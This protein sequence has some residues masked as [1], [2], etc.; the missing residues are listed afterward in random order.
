MQILSDKHID[1]IYHLAD[2]HIRPLDRHDEYRHV[3]D[4]LY[5]FLKSKE[6]IKDSLI[7]ICGDIIHEKDK[8]TPELILLLRE[9]LKNLSEITDVV[10]FSGNHDLIEN[11]LER[12]P[13]LEALTQ[14]ISDNIHY[15]RYTGSYKY[16]SIVFSLISL[17]DCGTAVENAVVEND[18]VENKEDEIIKIGLYHGMLKEIAHS[19]GLLSVT[20][21]E[22]YDYVLLGD[23]HERQFLKDNIAYSGSL[24]QQNFGETLD[25]HGL[26]RWDLYNN[27]NECIDIPNDY[28]YVTIT[29]ENY[30]M[31]RLPKNS[32]IRLKLTDDMD[33][34]KVKSMINENTN[35]ISEKII[36]FKTVDDKIKYEEQFIKNIN[37][38]DIIREQVLKIDKSKLD[39][40][41]ELHKQIKEECDFDS[42]NISEYKWSIL[43]LEFKNLF[44]YGDNILNKVDFTDKN[45]VIGILGN[46]A[47]G[48]SSIINIIIFALF[49]KIS[50]EYKNSANVINKNSKKMYVKIEFIVG[51][52][53][54]IIEKQGALQ[55]MKGVFRSKFE[56]NFKKIENE[57]EINLNGKDQIR[58][59]QLIVK[60][61][62]IQDIFTL[63]NI[64]S[65]TIVVSLLNMSDTE[66]INTFSKLFYLNIYE[67]FEKNITIK[68]KKINEEYNQ[69]KGRYSVLCDISDD[70]IIMKK[71][72]FNEKRKV[73]TKHSNELNKL[74]KLFNTLKVRVKE[75][76][77]AIKFIEKPIKS[78]NDLIIRQEYLSKIKDVNYTIKYSLEELYKNYHNE[79]KNTSDIELDDLKEIFKNLNTPL[80]HLDI[81]K[82][83]EFEHKLIK[84]NYN[85]N[86][87]CNE[88]QNYSNHDISNN[89]KTET[90]E[91]LELLKDKFKLIS[92]SDKQDIIECDVKQIPILKK[93]I[94]E[95]QVIIFSDSNKMALEASTL[96]N[97]L[98]DRC[99]YSDKLEVFK[100]EETN[101]FL[102]KIEIFL[103]RLKTDTELNN[104]LSELK[105]DIKNYDTLI[106]HDK[107]N[108]KIIELNKEI[109]KN[110]QLN[111][112]AKLELDKI[113]KAISF[114]K[115]N[116]LNTKIDIGNKAKQVLTDDIQEINDYSY[117][118]EI[119][120]KI[121]KIEENKQ[122]DK[123]ITYLKQCSELKAINVDLTC[124]EKYENT[125]EDNL[126]YQAEKDDCEFEM[127]NLNN[128]IKQ[129]SFEITRINTEITYDNDIIKK[130]KK[131]LKEKIKSENIQA[132]MENKIDLY[133]LYKKL[134]DKKCIRALLLKEKLR[135]IENDINLHLDGLVNFEIE[136][137]M[138]DNSKFELNIIK[139]DIVLQP[140]MCS[141]YERFILNIMIKNSLNRYSYNN[142]S[143][144]FCIDEGLDCIDDNNLKKFKVV[145]D[146]LQQTYN[147]IILISQIDRIDKYI[148]YQIL[149]EHK[150]NS[151][152]IKAE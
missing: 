107:H 118:Y 44:I 76:T 77:D 123:D 90:V 24:I 49:G 38:E 122:T 112:K 116:E 119:E 113:N 50:G 7:V 82:L 86:N 10:L 134:V 64:V 93:Q 3:F 21:F 92:I 74:N 104:I 35:V 12:V 20:D 8:I 95:K 83:N 84:V 62:S 55:K 65:N 128:K 4:N 136:M 79:F 88:L 135:F 129:C 149:I 102:N 19:N 69:E 89:Y 45:G 105:M 115:Y 87:Y 23:I 137:S 47:I 140:Y 56:T 42:T 57:K 75:V 120:N 147:H 151:S 148:D 98:K 15:L 126:K 67:E 68:L 6:N 43:R 33:L 100:V 60:I 14:N 53:H 97:E 111:E 71:N 80:K 59:Q 108:H 28:G 39:D 17:E 101:L 22:E 124:Y 61:I 32:R 46:N 18:V 146:R 58:T 81:C 1:Y 130:Y 142:K 36:K 110:I 54:Y 94:E 40:I 139:N 85:L 78:K 143:N 91:E 11:N 41:F 25:K 37:D 127:D 138:N 72:E 70:D 34:E 5:K 9:F 132:D 30:D 144:L 26:I 2:I 63:C 131:Q 152:Y 150:N 66:I 117:Y 96:K 16:G 103:N 13:N 29:D 31:N 109:D 48:K 51:N 73:R 114:I 99:F 141:G 106:E 52:I 145:L 121:N 27:T 125:L 133:K